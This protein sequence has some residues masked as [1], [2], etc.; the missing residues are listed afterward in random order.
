VEDAVF[1]ALEKLPA[2]RFASAKEFAAALHQPEGTSARPGARRAVAPRPWQVPA[3]AVALGAAVL[4]AAFGWMRP[5]EATSGPL[6]YRVTADSVLDMRDWT[7]N[8][9]ISPD[10]QILVRGSGPGGPLLKRTRDVLDFTPI[11]GTI[12]AQA[13]CFSPDGARV[14]FF[15]SGRLIAVP[16]GGGATEV[17]RANLP[18]PVACSWSDDGFVYFE[19]PD[20]LTIVRLRPEPGADVEVVA[21]ADTANGEIMHALPEALPDGGVLFNI[22]YR[23][24]RFMQAIVDGDTHRALFPATRARYLPSGHLVFGTIDGRMWLAAFDARR[25]ELRGEPRQIAEGMAQ[26]MTGPTNFAVS[27]SGILVYAEEDRKSER[28]LVWIT[29]NGTRSAVDSTWHAAFVGPRLSP[30]GRTLAVTVEGDEESQVWIKSVAGGAARRHTTGPGVFDE[31][32]W[33]PDGQGLSYVTQQQRVG[34]VALRALSGGRA[35]EVLL[36][37]DRS[38]SEQTWSPVGGWLVVR[39]TT[40]TAGAGD[41]L[42][43]RPGVDA[44]AIPTLSNSRSE[45]SPSV[46]RDGRWLAYASNESGRLE[47]YVVPFPEPDGRKWQLSAD[48]G[49]TPVWSPRGDELF[50]LDLLGNLVAVPVRTVAEFVP[51]DARV[52]FAAGDVATRAV[53]R[54]NYDVTPDGQRFVMVRRAGGVTTAP[55]IVVEQVV[56]LLTP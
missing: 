3:L 48:G 26:T 42:R 36:A 33:T 11:A 37:L 51:G 53:S 40:P 19:G 2:D 28:E 10:G 23:D 4:A 8:I 44:T 39:T 5:R 25:G 24:G 27:R 49:I 43:F 22:Q 18:G 35:P 41:V 17:L 54:R 52:L 20:A 29:R 38:I 1:Q 21:S 46:S 31:P 6:R 32:A 9:A 30:D 14:A 16:I 34:T 7:G 15:S 47:V 50:Y 55:M 12:G 13:P 56:S 45:Y